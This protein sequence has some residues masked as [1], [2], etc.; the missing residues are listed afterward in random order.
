MKQSIDLTWMDNMGFE[1]EL[2]GH[3]LT[4]DTNM[5]GGHDRGP[6]PKKLMLLSLAGCT[7]LDVVS[8]LKKM[9]VEPTY[10]NVKVEADMVDE[11]PR[12]YT[13]MHVT[14]EFRGENLPMDKL[15]KAV[16]LSTER[17]CGVSATL[18]QAVK[19]T[20]EIKILE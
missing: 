4:I 16:S 2:D 11:H 6:R 1:T 12:K 17:Y 15:E 10:F 20:H 14:Y 7:G 19:L 18:E 13:T 9:R 5:E 8:I 3:K